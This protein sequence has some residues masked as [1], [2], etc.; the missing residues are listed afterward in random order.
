MNP[1]DTDIYK[2]KSNG[3]LPAQGKI[4]ISE[5]FMVDKIFSRSVVLLIDHTSQGSMGLIL[6]KQLPVSLN[7]VIKEFTYLED[8][9]LF[10]GGPMGKDTLFFLHTLEEIPDSYPLGRGLFLN[11]NYTAIKKYI[12]QGNE[13]YGKIRFFVGYSGWEN[14]QLTNEISQDDWLVGTED[15]D[16]L[17]TA[18]AK[19]LWKDSLS[20]LGSKYE[21]WSHFP[22]F[23][24]LN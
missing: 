6:N 23:P 17:L 15:P 11:G 10:L 12:L 21:A 9:P 20:K 2:I 14:R 5:P 22:R 19:D 4:L 8:I 16:F 18:S 13:Y 7:Q 3:E 24:I 1:S